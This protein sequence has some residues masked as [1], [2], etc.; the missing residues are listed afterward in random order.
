MHEGDAFAFLGRFQIGHELARKPMN[1]LSGGEKARVQLPKLMLAGGNLLLLDEP[2]NN[3]DTL[4]SEALEDALDAYQRTVFVIS[5]DR[6]FL[7][8]VVSRVV[9]VADGALVEHPGGL[10]QYLERSRIGA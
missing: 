8:R 4:S 10:D 2:T 3:L 9:E 5:H 6:Y 7:D 1:T